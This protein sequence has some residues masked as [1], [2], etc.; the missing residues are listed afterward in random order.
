ME[1]SRLG[2][3]GSDGFVVACGALALVAGAGLALMRY[4]GGS[5]PERGVEGA[6][7]ALALGAGVAVSGL[8]ALLALR[9]RPALLLPSAIILLPASFLSFALVTLPL[10]VP[11][12][13][14][15]GAYRLRSACEGCGSVRAALATVTVLL[16]VMAALFA[17]FAHDDPRSYV[18]PIGG[19]SSSDVITFSE[20]LASLSLTALAV[21]AGWLFTAP[22]WRPIKP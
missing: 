13:M 19:G 12:G 14:L 3:A 2:V 8:L 7:G 5:P 6:L 22:E 21:V 15:L 4:V 18:T 11:A 10:L 9:E 1:R 16:L 17:L 20:S